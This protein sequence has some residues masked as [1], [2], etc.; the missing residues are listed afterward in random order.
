MIVELGLGLERNTVANADEL[1]DGQI[2]HALGKLPLLNTRVLMA[3]EMPEGPERIPWKNRGH[4]R[5]RHEQ[6]NISAGHKRENLPYQKHLNRDYQLV[7]V[8][9]GTEQLPGMLLSYWKM[10][11]RNHFLFKNLKW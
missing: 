7:S 11:D 8:F 3:L 2:R 10:M 5:D 9:Y 4:V 1:R 6:I